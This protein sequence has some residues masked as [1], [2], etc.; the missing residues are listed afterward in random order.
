M[1]VWLKSVIIGNVRISILKKRLWKIWWRLM[2]LWELPVGD[3]NSVTKRNVL[4]CGWW[5][6]IFA[7]E[8]INVKWNDHQYALNALRNA[9]WSAPALNALVSVISLSIVCKLLKELNPSI[10]MSKSNELMIIEWFDRENELHGEPFRKTSHETI[11][12]GRNN[13]RG[14]TGDQNTAWGIER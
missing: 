5:L 7:I 4:V 13:Q 8:N 9:I 11:R 14:M 3:G 1:N 2:V 6:K 12:K 10:L